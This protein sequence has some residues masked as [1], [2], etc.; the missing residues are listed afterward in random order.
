MNNSIAQSSHFYRT[1]STK[2]ETKT[3][4]HLVDV[5]LYELAQSSLKNGVTSLAPE[6]DAIG[7]CVIV[8]KCPLKVVKLRVGVA[9]LF[10]FGRLASL[11]TSSTTISA[12]SA[13]W[14]EFSSRLVRAELIF[15]PF[16]RLKSRASSGVAATVEVVVGL[17][18]IELTDEAFG[19]DGSIAGNVWC[20]AKKIQDFKLKGYLQ[21]F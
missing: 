8:L 16:L 9:P 11:A 4:A 7:E 6:D 21:N 14:L 3:K 12:V 20:W 2:C 13:S 19:I 10:A 5:E 1:E 18:M 15:R 17:V